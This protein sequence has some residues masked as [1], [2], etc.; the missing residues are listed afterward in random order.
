RGRGR[1]GRGAAR[2]CVRTPVAR[3]CLLRW[4]ADVDA[5]GRRTRHRRR[6][7]PGVLS[8]PSPGQA[9]EAAHRA[10]AEDL[11]AHGVRPRRPRPLRYLRRTAGGTRSPARGHDPRRGHRG[12]TRPEPR[13]DG[14]LGI[15]RSRRAAPAGREE[16]MIEPTDVAIDT[17]LAE[18]RD[19]LDDSVDAP[20]T[21][22]GLLE[23]VLVVG[24]GLELDS[25]L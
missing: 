1:R 14:S 19:R 5:R 2:P 8:S 7:R 9:G 12:R 21:L 17:L 6:P 10:P 4:P 13:E 18:L 3:W 25:M 20:T 23:A 16:V 22:R 24:S 11:D 15:R